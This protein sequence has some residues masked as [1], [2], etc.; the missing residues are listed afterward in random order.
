MM[1]AS[2][3]LGND[4]QGE[5]LADGVLTQEEY[6]LSVAAFAKCLSVNGIREIDSG[7]V[8]LQAGSDEA[9]V[10][11]T[12]WQ[13]HAQHVEEFRTWQWWRAFIVSTTE[14]IDESAGEPEERMA[15]VSPCL[16]YTSPSP[17][18]RG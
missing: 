6:D 9:E 8:A 15:T 12:C 3:E 10:A 4:L 7:T 16:L 13:V 5:S 17:R 1:A 14:D 11:S 2:L 18:D